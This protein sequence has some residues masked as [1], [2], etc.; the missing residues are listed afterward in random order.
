[1]NEEYFKAKEEKPQLFVPIFSIRVKFCFFSR[2]RIEYVLKDIFLPS[3]ILCYGDYSTYFVYHEF[4]LDSHWKIL[5]F[6]WCWRKNILLKHILHEWIF[7]I[8]LSLRLSYVLLCQSKVEKRKV[9]METRVWASAQKSQSSNGKLLNILCV[10]EK[11]STQNIC[12]IVLNQF[13]MNAENLFLF[14]FILYSNQKAYS[15]L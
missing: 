12:L 9:A 8:K 1:M 6:I 10:Y 2:Y 13:Y 4:L 3:F 5:H 14:I 7:Y 15:Q 11:G